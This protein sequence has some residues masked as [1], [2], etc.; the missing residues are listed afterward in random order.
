MH[1]L[2]HAVCL[3]ALLFVIAVTLFHCPTLFP[4]LRSFFFF[5]D[6]ATTEI[7]TLS[8]HDALPIPGLGHSCPVVW[9]DRVFVTTAVSGDPDPKVRTGNYGDVGSVNDTSKH[10]WR[11]Y[12]LDRD[13]GKVLWDRTACAGVPK[14]KRHLKGS[15]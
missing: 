1:D 6:P 14:V 10:S 12:C 13:S 4:Y 3:C 2:G 11:V 5:N 15:Q 7:Y 8:L 9:G